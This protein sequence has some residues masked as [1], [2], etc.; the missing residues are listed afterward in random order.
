M[1]AKKEPKSLQN[2]PKTHAENDARKNL[3]ILAFLSAAGSLR[4]SKFMLLLKEFNDFR[5]ILFSP[6]ER[7]RAPKSHQNEVQ[8]RCKT[9]QNSHQKRYRKTIAKKLQNIAQNDPKITPK[10][11]KS[12]SKM[13]PWA[14]LG[15]LWRPGLVLVAFWHH[16]CSIFYDF[17]PQFHKFP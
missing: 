5:K 16:F 10:Y 14:N 17:R 9:S 7:L 4:P 11:V 12:R 15:P 3:E 6:R 1:D 13:R 2:A 8:N